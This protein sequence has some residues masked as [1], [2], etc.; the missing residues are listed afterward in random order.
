MISEHPEIVSRL[1]DSPA[2]KLDIR[3]LYSPDGFLT[4]CGR[5]MTT[6]AEGYATFASQ[7]Q[8]YSAFLGAP[9]GSQGFGGQQMGASGNVGSGLSV[10]DDASTLF[11][12]VLEQVRKRAE[13]CDQL[14]GF[15][16]T[17]STAGGMSGLASNAL[18]ELSGLYDKCDKF[19]MVQHP[20]SAFCSNSCINIY[21]DVLSINSLIED[22]DFVADVDDHSLI[23]VCSKRIT[24]KTPYPAG[25]TSDFKIARRMKPGLQDTNFLFVDSILG[26]T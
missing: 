16:L 25:S 2:N 24:P 19:C 18:S 21:N 12:R 9:T 26:L 23:D 1:G 4:G 22:A 10:S 20:S 5:P 15:Q 3:A 7:Q 6:Y 17:Y 11:E 8:N 13:G 14:Q